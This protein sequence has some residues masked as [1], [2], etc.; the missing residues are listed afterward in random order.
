MLY[1]VHCMPA[2]SNFFKGAY[3][4][5][6]DKTVHF[7]ASLALTFFGLL[8]WQSSVVIGVVI[9]LG[10]LKEFRDML[11]PGDHF[12]WY[13]IMTNVLGVISGYIA[14]RIVVALWL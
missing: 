8:L 1:L 3:Y 2:I 10:I 4:G 11:R 14:W 9:G 13:D 5:R 7:T 12:D 6:Y